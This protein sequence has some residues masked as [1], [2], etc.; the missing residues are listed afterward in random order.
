M[1]TIKL[2]RNCKILEEKNFQVDD[3]EQYLAT[4]TPVKSF[5]NAQYIKMG[6][7]AEV[8]V[9]LDQTYLDKQWTNMYNYCSIELDDGGQDNTYYY[10]IRKMQWISKDAIK[11]ILHLDVLNTYK[12]QVKLTDKTTINRMH[13]DRF[14]NKINR[15]YTH[16]GYL[17]D[18]I[19]WDWDITEDEAIGKATFTLGVDFVGY[20]IEKKDVLFQVNQ[21]PYN[22]NLWDVSR[23]TVD[24]TITIT[25]YFQQTVIPQETYGI[26]ID[27]LILTRRIDFTDEGFNPVLY[28]KSDEVIYDASTMKWYL[29]YKTQQDISAETTQAVNTYL[30][31]ES[32]IL[33]KYRSSDPDNVLTTANYITGSTQYLIIVN[34]EQAIYNSLD[35]YGSVNGTDWSF[36]KHLDKNKGGAN[37][38]T[39]IKLI[40]SGNNIKAT[41]CVSTGRTYQETELGE[42]AKVRFGNYDR[43]FY[44][45]NTTSGPLK[46]WN[47]SG[48]ATQVVT[49]KS[50]NDINRTDATIIKIIELPYCPCTIKKEADGSFILNNYESTI[51]EYN[52]GVGYLEQRNY[53]INTQLKGVLT[54]E[55]NP[56][57]ELY[58]TTNTINTASLRNDTYES[59]LYHSAFHHFK[60]VYDSFNYSINLENYNESYLSE[61][62]KW[63]IDYVVA[64]TCNT[65]FLFNFNNMHF[66]YSTQD[67]DTIMCCSRNNEVTITNSNYLQYLRTGYNYDQ[68]NKSIAITQSLLGTGTHLAQGAVTGAFTGGGSVGA[69]AGALIGAGAGITNTVM[70]IIQTERSFEQK[71]VEMK[72]QAGSVSGA[73]DLDLLRYYANDNKMKLCLYELSNNTKE[74]IA[75]LFYYCGYKCDYQDVPNTNSRY[76]FNF[77]QCDPVYDCDNT[78]AKM[79][80]DQKD[81]LTNKYREGVTVLHHHT[82]WDFDQ[83]K[84][85]WEL[86]IIPIL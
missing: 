32:P 64:N 84:E 66:K 48:S 7:D 27:T 75:D 65:R 52:S 49:L 24:N 86:T 3:I 11:L 44:K 72:N 36:V 2:Y 68:K 8:K 22:I 82:T 14:V 46:V 12:D 9:N 51:W 33:L 53:T 55:T 56:L 61:K 71:Q 40:K 59:K 4:L 15:T 54:P 58:C 81:E 17:D 45:E 77:I 31:P 70:S 35:M 10:F 43:L 20:P 6:L 19:E 37:L 60:Y 78:T 34:D 13:K 62:G 5:D 76:W 28:K 50:I 79:S 38:T 85:N 74:R 23:N 63:E 83:V 57:L 18:V 69:A 67:Y 73:D 25:V 42:Y 39:W 29:M 30:L 16:T 1:S 26:F 80:K 41:Y 21:E 47:F